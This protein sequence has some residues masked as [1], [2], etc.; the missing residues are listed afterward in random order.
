VSV[1]SNNYFSEK[2]L[3]PNAGRIKEITLSKI[4][5]AF[6]EITPSQF[7]NCGYSLFRKDAKLF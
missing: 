6:E 3:F 5:K 4:D 2:E 7:D 1:F